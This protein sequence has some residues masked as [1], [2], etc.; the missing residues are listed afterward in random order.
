MIKHITQFEILIFIICTEIFEGG[1]EGGQLKK[2]TPPPPLSLVLIAAGDALMV[3][4]GNLVK[5]V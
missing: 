2:Q 3:P 5:I 4:P 1:G